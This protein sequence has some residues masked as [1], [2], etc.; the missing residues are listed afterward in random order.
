MLPRGASINGDLTKV[1]EV[2]LRDPNQVQEFVAHS[3]F[4]YDQPGKGL[5]PWDGETV[6]HYELG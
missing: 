2:D 4:K 6:P 5:H 3:W 1:H